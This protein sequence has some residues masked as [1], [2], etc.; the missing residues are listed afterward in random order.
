MGTGSELYPARPGSPSP[1]WRVA[2]P[3][4]A[5][6]WHWGLP[7]CSS[8]GLPGFPLS[9][10]RWPAL[11]GSLWPWGAEACSLAWPAEFVLTLRLTSYG[12]PTPHP[13]H[14]PLRC[15]EATPLQNCPSWPWL[16]RCP[17]P[18]MSFLLPTLPTP[19][20][21]H[22]PLLQ[23]AH[24]DSCWLPHPSSWLSAQWAG[25]SLLRWPLPPSRPHASEVS[26]SVE[27]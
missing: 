16:Q 19:S 4:W 7:H 10:G 26:R 8:I 9:C 24:Q 14:S 6:R 20:F 12:P 18:G 23:Q 2:L 22:C 13:T 1:V 17:L 5:E 25:V 27:H 15:R 21:L 3:T 11:T